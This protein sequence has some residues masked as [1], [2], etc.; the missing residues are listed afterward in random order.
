MWTKKFEA[1]NT[2]LETNSNNRNTKFN[3]F[4]FGKLGDLNFDIVSD[5]SETDASPDIRISSF[6]V[7]KR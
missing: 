6:R 3:A 7:F 5:W 1:R 4:P 2:K